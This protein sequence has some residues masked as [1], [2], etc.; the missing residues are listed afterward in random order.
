MVDADQNSLVN[1]SMPQ[2]L[3]NVSPR[4][5]IYPSG[6]RDAAIRELIDRSTKEVKCPMCGSIFR[7]LSGLRMLEADHIIPW[8]QRGVTTWENLQLL[9]RACN[10]IKN[11]HMPLLDKK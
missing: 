5:R 11:N 8:A 7:G 3:E 10:R 1:S 9:C 4:D 2:N 6:W